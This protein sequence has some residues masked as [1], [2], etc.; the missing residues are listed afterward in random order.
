MTPM[1]RARQALADLADL[2]V[3]RYPHPPFVPRIWELRHHVTAYDVAYVALAEVLDAPLL[4]GDAR[5]A[6]APG[7]AAAI[8]LI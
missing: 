1:L 5:L 4:T 2:A 8:E 6:G 7:H 3:T